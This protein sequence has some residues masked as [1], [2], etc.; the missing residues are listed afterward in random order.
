MDTYTT[1]AHK[2][3]GLGNHLEMGMSGVPDCA[4]AAQAL[5]EAG[6][7]RHHRSPSVWLH[8]PP[9]SRLH[10]AAE[11]RRSRAKFRVERALVNEAAAGTVLSP[12][13]SGGGGLLS[14]LKTKS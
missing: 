7:M 3:Q 6:T 12:G 5:Q 4:L 10:A 9:V 8:L 13:G 1:H 2:G 11:P 14:K